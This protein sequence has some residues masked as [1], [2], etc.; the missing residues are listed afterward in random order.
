MR[1]ECVTVAGERLTPMQ[2]HYGVGEDN[3]LDC[4]EYV[5]VS[6]QQLR[7][8]VFLKPS[9][10]ENFPSLV[11]LVSYSDTPCFALDA[12]RGGLYRHKSDSF[13]TLIVTENG[14]NMSYGGRTVSL[15]RGEKYFI[16]ANSEVTL[17]GVFG[18]LSYPP[19]A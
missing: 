15:L 2:I 10:S 9:E 5:G 11:H 17:E 13:V 1:A 19:K 16:P 4:F 8:H 7:S 14:G 18:L 12:V 3:M 6:E